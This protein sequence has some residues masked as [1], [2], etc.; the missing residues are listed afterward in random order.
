MATAEMILSDVDN[1]NK[2]AVLYNKKNEYLKM[3]AFGRF[4]LSVSGN[5]LQLHI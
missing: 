3:F 5:L 4:L 1:D 2:D